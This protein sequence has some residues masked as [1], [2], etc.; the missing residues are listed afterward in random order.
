MHSLFL[1][2]R[3]TLTSS[4]YRALHSAPHSAVTGPVDTHAR[5]SGST[6]KDCKTVPISLH[7]EVRS[8]QRARCQRQT[9]AALLPAF[10]YI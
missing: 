9:L 2:D 7:S 5:Y 3:L 6:K 8:H 1:A 4:K 10:V